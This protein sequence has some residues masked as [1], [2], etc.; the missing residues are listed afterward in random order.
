[1]VYARSGSPQKARPYFSA[2]LALGRRMGSTSG[3]TA[4]VG[5][6]GEIRI[7][8]GD[9]A[10]GLAHIGLAQGHPATTADTRLD[11]ND[12][13][14]LWQRRLGLANGVLEAGLQAGHALDLDAVL[15]EIAARTG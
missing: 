6:E 4:L 2:A 1:M 10:G 9:V 5:V 15:Q 13:L 7:A 14:S 11:I 8:E 3:Y 12:G